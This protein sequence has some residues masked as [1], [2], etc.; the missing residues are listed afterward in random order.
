M[1]KFQI[2]KKIEFEDLDAYGLSTLHIR[3]TSPYYKALRAEMIIARTL[4]QILFFG[5]T[6]M[7]ELPEVRTFRWRGDN[8]GGY[9]RGYV[10]NDIRR[11]WA[12]YREKGLDI[13]T[14][15]IHTQW[16]PGTVFEVNPIDPVKK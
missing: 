12:Y 5:E 1:T 8:R 2:G 4:L 7:Q 13:P 14:P 15:P 10:C 11:Y 6:P 9:D 16:P 3:C